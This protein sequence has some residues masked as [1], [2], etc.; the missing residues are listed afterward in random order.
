MSH[1]EVHIVFDTDT[2]RFVDPIS[3][4]QE[5]ALVSLAPGIRIIGY[6]SH[7]GKPNVSCSA[8]VFPSLLSQSKVGFSVHHVW[9]SGRCA[10]A[11]ARA[12]FK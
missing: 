12:E 5:G 7:V 9:P 2:N 11:C 1:A 8:V 3:I 6:G 4:G 10:N